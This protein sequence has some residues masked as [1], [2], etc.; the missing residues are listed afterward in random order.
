LQPENESEMTDK[1]SNVDA[2]HGMFK[3][4]TFNDSSLNK[5]F[6]SNDDPKEVSLVFHLTQIEFT[7]ELILLGLSCR[8]F[9]NL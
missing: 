6:T 8:D 1:Y 2:S 7:S 9:L 5:K 4:E 3:D